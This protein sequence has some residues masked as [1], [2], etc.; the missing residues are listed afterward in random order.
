[1]KISNLV[2]IIF[3]IALLA[4][5]VRIG[6]QPKHLKSYFRELNIE[7]LSGEAPHFG[8]VTLSG[9]TISL[10]RFKGSLLI[11]H[12]WATWCQPCR[13]EL[14]ALEKL[15]LQVKNLPVSV[16]G[17]SIDQPKDSLQISLA[18]KAMKLTFPNAAAF[19]GTISADYWTW[20]IPVTYLIDE[21][22]RFLGRVRGAGKWGD[23]KMIE[24]L[25]LLCK[26]LAVKSP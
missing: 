10:E 2:K 21:N 12:V 23:S 24:L 4:W 20:G 17:I 8:L 26:S 19:S 11:L 5:S 25:Q 14:P 3:L 9:D 22:S 13:K 6:A 7:S 18:V 16:L 15:H 1:M